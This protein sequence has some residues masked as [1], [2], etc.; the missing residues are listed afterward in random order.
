MTQKLLNVN[1][2]ITLPVFSD[3]TGSMIVDCSAGKFSQNQLSF[4]TPTLHSSC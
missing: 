4:T 2:K 3:R 1:K